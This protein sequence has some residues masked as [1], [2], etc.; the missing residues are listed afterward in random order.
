MDCSEKNISTRSTKHV[1]RQSST[2]TIIAMWRTRLQETL[3]DV[4]DLHLE[5]AGRQNS[6][7]QPIGN[8]NHTSALI[9][10]KCLSIKRHLALA[11]L[12]IGVREMT[13]QLRLQHPVELVIN[14]YAIFW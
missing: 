6:R 4:D 12:A 5:I 14:D 3:L 13:S 7:H 2:R 8:D 1:E 11:R 10:R 9:Q